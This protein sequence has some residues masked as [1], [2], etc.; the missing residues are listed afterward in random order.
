MGGMHAHNS[1]STVSSVHMHVRGIGP[2]KKNMQCPRP[3]PRSLSISSAFWSQHPLSIFVVRSLSS[4][5]HYQKQCRC[6]ASAS[7]GSSRSSW[8]GAPGARQDACR[9]SMRLDSHSHHCQQA[10]PLCHLAAHSLVRLHAPKLCR[11]EGGSSL[12]ISWKMNAQTLR[13][14]PGRFS[15]SSCLRASGNLRAC[16]DLQEIALSSALRVL[17]LQRRTPLPM[18]LVNLPSPRPPLRLAPDPPP[19]LPLPP[20]R[21]AL[22]AA[23]PSLLRCPWSPRR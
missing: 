5:Q 23:C 15:L 16:G 4:S 7:A 6:N 9:G 11:V 8:D 18:I 17:S 10:C 12:S 21:A 3:W 20:S 2:C 19:P 22:H 1:L 13:K 14:R